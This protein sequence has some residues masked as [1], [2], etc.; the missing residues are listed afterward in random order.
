MVFLIAVSYDTCE[1]GRFLLQE[2]ALKCDHDP[3]F[4]DLSKNSFRCYLTYSVYWQPEV[5]HP[6]N[7]RF[8]EPKQY[9]SA[10]ALKNWYI[11]LTPSARKVLSWLKAPTTV[12]V[13]TTPQNHR[14]NEEKQSLC[15]C[16][17]NFGTFLCRPLQNNNVNWLNSRFCGEPVH[18]KGNFSIPFLTG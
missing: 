6:G 17:L 3:K 5:Q 16:V 4:T 9:H 15:M 2:W 1:F 12:T 8:N 7:K 10:R 13:A 11:S 14:F 18:T